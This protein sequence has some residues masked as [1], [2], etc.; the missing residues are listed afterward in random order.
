GSLLPVL[1]GPEGARPGQNRDNFSMAVS[2][3]RDLEWPISGRPAWLFLLLGTMIAGAGLAVKSGSD[4]PSLPHEESRVGIESLWEAHCQQL[5]RAA[6]RQIGA[7]Y[8][9]YSTK[10]Q[11]SVLD[12]VR[13]CLEFASREGVHV[14]LEQIFFALGSSGRKARRPGYQALEGCLAQKQ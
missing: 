7:I 11:S 3:S 2:R 6:A 8:A 4:A 13:P 5:P 12:Q 1:T 9:R 14:P 10:G